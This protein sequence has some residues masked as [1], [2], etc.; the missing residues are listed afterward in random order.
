M[1]LFVPVC[2]NGSGDVKQGWAMSMITELSGPEVNIC[3]ISDS[4]AN[5][6]C[7]KMASEFLKTDCDAM[8]IVDADITFTRK[9]IARLIAHFERGVKLVYGLYPKKHDQTEPCVCTFGE[10]PVPDDNDLAVV[11]R[12]GRGF[13]LVAREV[14]ERMKE[15]NGGPALRYHNHDEIQWDFFPSGPVTGEHSAFA[16]AKDKDGYAM[17][18]WI[19]EDWYF[20]ERARIWL[21]VPTLVDTGIALGH[22]GPKEYRFQGAQLCRM[23]ANINSWKDVQ[24]WFDYE[25]VYRKIVAAIPDGG[26]FVE[27]G[28]WLG[29]SIGAF[30]AF[31]KEAGKT[32]SIQVVDTFKGEAA[33]ATHKAIM[34]AHG[35]SV[36]AHF[37]ANMNALGISSDIGVT[38][39]DSA[40]SARLFFDGLYDAVFIDASHIEEDVVNDIRAWLPKVKPGG[41][42]AGHDIDEA[43]VF[44]AVSVTLGEVE[45]IGRCWL[46][47]V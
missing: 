23:D 31:A 24:G 21:G 14:F 17:R 11:R 4:H 33:N 34:D 16:D 25:D 42:L 46:V 19:S 18:E 32:I 45:T 12:A 10:I 47:K 2:N 20:C 26:S 27:V 8:L 29:K 6:Q 7:N 36:E 41:I 22:I 15:D 30:H 13:M 39:G 9:D 44:S 43:G 28:C 35:G 37:R 5:R 1:K 40:K 38:V 3:G